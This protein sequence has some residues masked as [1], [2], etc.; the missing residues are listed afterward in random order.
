[1]PD[2]R[3]YFLDADERIRAAQDIEAD[4]A[5]AAVARVLEMLKERPHHRSVEVWQGARR[6]YPPRGEPPEIRRV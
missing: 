2:F 5:S 6:V 3:C 1:M 4:A